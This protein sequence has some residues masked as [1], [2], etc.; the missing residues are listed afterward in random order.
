M[1]AW[2]NYAK[3]AEQGTGGEWPEI[4]DDLY[5]AMIQDISEPATKADPFNAG[6]EKT[7]FYITWELYGDVPDGTTLR[8]WITIPEGYINDGYLSDKSNLFKLMEALGFDLSGKFRVD[9]PSWQ[10]MEARVLVE[11]KPNKDGDLRP[12]ITD[13][14]APRRKAADKPAAKREP[15]GAAAKRGGAPFGEDDEE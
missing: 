10:G 14:K 3:D 11:N 6:K 8:Q 4:S 13:V 9:P 2:D 12:R 15:V 7:D 1:G 5:P